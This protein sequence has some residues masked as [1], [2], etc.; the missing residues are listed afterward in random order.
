MVGLLMLIDIGFIRAKYPNLL[1]FRD[2]YLIEVKMKILIC[3]ALTTILLTCGDAP[4]LFGQEWAAQMADESHFDFGKVFEGQS[5]VHRFTIT[6][7]SDVELTLSPSVSAGLFVVSV[8]ADLI[9]PGESAEL[10]C[11]PST[12]TGAQGVRKATVTL[13]L[14]GGKIGELQFTLSADL[15]PKIKLSKP[16]I[17]F[18]DFTPGSDSVSDCYISV[19]KNSG[20]RLSDIKSKSDFISGKV[21]R[22]G[23]TEDYLV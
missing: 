3:I 9:R 6:N 18:S 15:V 13:R 10:I 11:R 8:S 19:S 23:A 22:M 4:K 21:I 2:H 14:G 1:A 5:R 16:V 12:H 7:T 20:L 17:H